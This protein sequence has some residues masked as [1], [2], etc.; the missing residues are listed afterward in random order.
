MEIINSEM[1]KLSEWFG[2]NKL[3]IN[4]KKSNYMTFQPRQKR[5]KIDLSI[6]LNNHKID[7]V[8]EVV[9]LGVILDEH[10]S[11]KPHISHV[12]GKLSKSIGII[13][14]S[15]FCLSRSSLITLYYS[16]IYP[17]LQ[18]CIIV[19]GSRLRCMYIKLFRV[20]ELL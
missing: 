8:K 5:Q 11:W 20:L 16:L 13:Y 3:S 6:T 10:L 14:K 9:F 17:Y 18:Y 4:V 12:A 7:Q 19:W 15:S 1:D 2:A